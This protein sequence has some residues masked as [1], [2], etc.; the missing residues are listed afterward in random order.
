[1]SSEDQSH[2]QMPSLVESSIANFARQPTRTA[3]IYIGARLDKLRLNLLQLALVG[4]EC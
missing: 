3:W 1:M 2:V 4:T